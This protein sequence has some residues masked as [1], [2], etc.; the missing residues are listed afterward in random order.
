M[1]VATALGVCPDL[2]AVALEAALAP[3][4]L[5]FPSAAARAAEARS[6]SSA[7]ADQVGCLEP[8]LCPR[9]KPASHNR[10]PQRKIP[11]EAQAFSAP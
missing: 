11:H 10:G 5:A 6:V 7:A 1:V 9:G 3:E 2:V 4:A 8:R